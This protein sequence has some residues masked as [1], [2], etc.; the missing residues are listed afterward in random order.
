MDFI[1]FDLINSQWY[2]SHDSIEPLGTKYW[3]D[4]FLTKWRFNNLEMPSSYQV[5]QLVDLRTLLISIFNEWKEH[6]NISKEL[7]DKLNFFLLLCPVFR[8]I[9][10]EDHKLKLVTKPLDYNWNYIISEIALSFAELLLDNQL[11]NIKICEN[12]DCKFIFYDRSKNHT[13]RWCCDS[14]GNLMKVRR[15]RAKQKNL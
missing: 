8:S 7:L 9:E 1:C 5:N 13:K 10:N 4:K 15:F 6:N 14:C 12:P 11:D 3:I 2:V